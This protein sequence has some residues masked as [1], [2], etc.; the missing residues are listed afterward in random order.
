MRRRHT[1]IGVAVG[2]VPMTRD[3]RGIR[4]MTLLEVI[5]AASLMAIVLAVA[6]PNLPALAAPFTLRT[7]SQQVAADLVATRMRAIARD[8]RYRVAFNTA[9]ATYAIEGETTPGQFVAEGGTR[10]LPRGTMLGAV[11]VNPVFDSRG[12][13]AAPFVLLVTVP[14]AGTRTVS[15]NVLG[16]TTVE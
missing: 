8:T 9:A 16:Q 14:G 12:M 10:T 5:V 2:I 15:V 6:V 4:G 7:A 1:G 3:A 13:L 11:A